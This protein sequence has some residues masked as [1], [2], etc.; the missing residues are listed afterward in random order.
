MSDDPLLKQD[1]PHD[2][3]CSM[4]LIEPQHQT[5]LQSGLDVVPFTLLLGVN[6]ATRAMAEKHTVLC[7]RLPQMFADAEANTV[8]LPDTLVL[9]Y[10]GS[11]AKTTTL[12]ELARITERHLVPDSRPEFYLPI[13][14]RP[15][16]WDAILKFELALSK[17]EPFLCDGKGARQNGIL[18]P[19]HAWD[20]CDRVVCVEGATREQ[21][22]AAVKERRLT[23]DTDY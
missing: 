9:L 20:L 15:T 11:S 23:F 14:L 17:G 18:T 22:L 1:L 3:V 8:M 19:K 16:E 10:S 5:R 7:H 2:A 13:C 6:D 12:R 4:A 21:A